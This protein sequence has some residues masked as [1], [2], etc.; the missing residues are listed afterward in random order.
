[1]Y[2]INLKIFFHYKGCIN[3]HIVSFMFLRLLITVFSN[4][5]LRFQNNR[6]ILKNKKNFKAYEHALLM[7]VA[8]L[9]LFDHPV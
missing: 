8:L 3:C 2:S 5:I 7:N 4:S 6:L 1:M 9:F